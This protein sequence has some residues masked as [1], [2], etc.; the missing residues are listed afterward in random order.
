MLNV[1]RTLGLGRKREVNRFPQRGESIS[2]PDV[3][4]GLASIEC[5]EECSARN[6]GCLLIATEG[7]GDAIANNSS[8]LGSVEVMFSLSSTCMASGGCVFEI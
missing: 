2:E 3:E 5:E 1:R 6:V 8:R 4:W 7:G